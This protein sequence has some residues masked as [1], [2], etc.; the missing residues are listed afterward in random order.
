VDY[1]AQRPLTHE[2]DVTASQ[3]MV[4]QKEHDAR[5]EEVN[6]CMDLLLVCCR[7]LVSDQ[8]LAGG[9]VEFVNRL[10]LTAVFARLL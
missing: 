7:F 8:R 10:D 3:Q 1:A 5:V 9:L 2:H 6:S 4:L